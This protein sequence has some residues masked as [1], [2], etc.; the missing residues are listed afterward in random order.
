MRFTLLRRGLVRGRTNATNVSDHSV[1]T[2]WHLSQLGSTGSCYDRRHVRSYSGTSSC[3]SKKRSLEEHLRIDRQHLWHP[4]TSLIDPTP[5]L[6]V[7]HAEGCTLYVDQEQSAEPIP[8]VDGMS[9][10]WAAVWGYNHPKLN[11][12]IQSQVSQMS[13]VMFGGLTH[14]P[15]TQLATNLLDLIGQYKNDS[16]RTLDKIFYADSGSVAVEVALKMSLQY[17]RGMG[18]PAKKQILS[19]RGG[20]H[21]DTFGAMSVCDPVGGMHSAFQGGMLAEQRFVSRPPCDPSTR[22]GLGLHDSNVNITTQGCNGCTCGGSVQ[23]HK[24]AL[25]EALEDLQRT[26]ENHH[27]SLAA[28]IVEPLVQGA[29]G[30][31]FYSPTYLQ[32][33]RELCKQHDMLLI[34][35]EIATGFGRASGK[36]KEY[37]FASHNAGIQ[38]DIMCLGKALTG[39]YMT[40]GVVLTTDQVARGVSSS[41]SSEDADET[42]PALPLMHGPTFM[43]NPLACS[44]AV[45]STNLFLERDA[46]GNAIWKGRVEGIELRLRQLLKEAIH[47]PSV[48]DVRVNGAIGVIELKDPLVTSTQEHKWFLQRCQ[49]LGVWL[50]PFGRLLYTM[51][52]YISSDQELTQICNAMLTLA[53]EASRKRTS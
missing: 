27:P 35:D 14:R 29:G 48:A 44:A 12:A 31:R 6:S 19:V 7:S 32:R 11:E 23:N 37:L 38:P 47:L 16:S 17:W 18:K 2:R 53:D 51:P 4:Y 30:M 46:H 24:A 8:I 21:G 26:I 39:G 41:P 36:G 22:L 50:R 10:W 13:H 25:D 40:M 5:V 28:L 9:S 33:A 45:A 3:C 34:C 52:P 43:G 42:A 20:Y 49:Q 1:L 15:A